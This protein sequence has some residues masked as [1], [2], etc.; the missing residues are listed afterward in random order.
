MIKIMAGII[1][2]NPNEELLCKCID[3]IYY[4]VNIIVVIDNASDIPI[5]KLLSGYQRLVLIKNGNNQGIAQALS[6]LMKYA[7]DNCYDW[8]LTLDQDTI[9]D[10]NLIKKYLDYIELP[11]IGALSCIVYD[12]NMGYA[13]C[14]ESKDY[15]TVI[16]CITAGCMMNVNAYNQTE[17]YDTWMFIDKVDFDICYALRSKGYKI[18]RINYEGISH[19]VGN[20]RLIKFLNKTYKIMNHEPLRRYYMSRNGVYV[21]RKY[22]GIVPFWRRLFNEMRDI[23]LVFFYEDRKTEKL[24]YSIRGIRDAFLK[25]IL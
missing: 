25:K 24:V 2:Y 22:K 10:G 15:Y 5:D 3:A 14:S 1:T 16:D 12:R 4:Q 9:A 20:G 7:N 17:G 11:N 6:N 21:A 23:I 18:Y 8:V 13:S 19:E